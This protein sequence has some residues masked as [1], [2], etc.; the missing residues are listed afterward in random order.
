MTPIRR[1]SDDATVAIAL[2]VAPRLGG[3]PLFGSKASPSAFKAVASLGRASG[4]ACRAKVD[5][6][7]APAQLKAVVGVLG[8]RSANLRSEFDQA[9]GGAARFA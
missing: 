7:Q 4:F 9:L 3:G 1:G 6:V 2:A 8:F 5:S